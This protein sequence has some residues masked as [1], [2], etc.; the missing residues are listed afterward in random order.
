MHHQ[1]LELV[2]GYLQQ[3]QN[4]QAHLVNQLGL[5]HLLDLLVLYH[6]LVLGY[7][8][9]YP[10]QDRQHPKRRGHH[11]QDSHLLHFL[12]AVQLQALRQL[13]MNQEW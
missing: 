1:H 2:E 10:T 7:F 11:L 5:S 3:L 4:Y 6:Q 9:R 13:C 8:Q 12:L